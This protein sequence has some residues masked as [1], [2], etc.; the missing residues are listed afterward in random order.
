MDK[1]GTEDTVCRVY[2]IYSNVIFLFDKLMCQLGSN[3]SQSVVKF[4]CFAVEREVLIFKMLN[5]WLS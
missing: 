3:Y 1:S 4:F 5:V 2:S